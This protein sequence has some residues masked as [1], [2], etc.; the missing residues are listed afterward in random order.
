MPAGMERDELA[1]RIIMKRAGIHTFKPRPNRS[2][3]S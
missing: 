2:V 3:P 1:L